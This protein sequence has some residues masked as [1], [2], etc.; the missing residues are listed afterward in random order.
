MHIPRDEPEAAASLAP[1]LILLL[2]TLL[3][4]GWAWS[5]ARDLAREGQEAHQ[6]ALVA[7]ILRDLHHVRD[8]GRGYP[9]PGLEP[10]L[11][12][13]HGAWKRRYGALVAALGENRSGVSL[14]LEEAYREYRRAHE[15]YTRELRRAARALDG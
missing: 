1:S 15:D 7:E 4:L 13:A 8:P 5:H 2:L 9:D 14:Q 11:A 6:Q 10:G 3:C 12:A